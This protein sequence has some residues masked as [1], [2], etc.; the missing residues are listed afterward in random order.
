MLLEIC[1][2]LNSG[3]IS[4]AIGAQETVGKSDHKAHGV[5]PVRSIVPGVGV[6]NL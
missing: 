3:M 2:D 4:G 1:P 5:G 6:M